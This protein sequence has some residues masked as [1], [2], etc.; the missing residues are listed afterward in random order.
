MAGL[1]LPTLMKVEPAEIGR[2]AIEG[3]DGADRVVLERGEAGRWRVVEPVEALAD[4]VQ[5]EVLIGN[6]R[7][8]RREA[9]GSTLDGDPATYGLDEPDRVVR[10]YREGEDEPVATLAVGDTLQRLRYVRPGDGPVAMAEAT[11]LE[12]ADLPPEELAEPGP[13]RHLLV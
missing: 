10:L 7:Q 13:L 1:V 8:L 3:P 5:V 11:R 2:I 9:P 4:G 12:Q 6:L